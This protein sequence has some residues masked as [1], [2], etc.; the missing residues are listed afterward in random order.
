MRIPDTKYFR[1][2]AVLFFLSCTLSLLAQGKTYHVKVDSEITASGGDGLSWDK[3]ITLESALSL[4]KAGDEIWVKGYEDITGHIYKAPKGGFVLPSGVAMY[5]GFAGNETIKNDLPTGRHKYQMKYQTALV[6]DINTNDKASQQLIIYPENSTR[7]DNATHVLTLQMGVTKD[8]TNDG[9]KPTIVSGFLIAAGNAKGE[10]TSANGRGGGIYVVNNSNDNNAGSRY[11]RI[12]QC[13]F[14]N[15]YGMRGG[16]IYVD[17]S[18]TNQQSAIS[19]CSIFNNV[20]G[21]RGTSENEGGGM[22]IDGTATV[23]NC[24][25]NN[26]TNGGI[27]LSNT[28]KIVNC[29]VIANTVSAADLT[30]DGASN[31]NGGGAVYNTVL[32]HSTALSKQD[33]RPAFYS[34]AFPEVEVTDSKT[35]TDA[36]GN[37]RISNEN[38]GIEPAPWFKQSAV[39]Q[40]YDFSFS[41][42]L[43][44]L[45]STAFTF[46]ETSA[47]LNKGKLEYYKNLV[48]DANLE[49]AS[50]DIMG[51]TRYQTSSIDIGAY[52]YARMKAGRIRYVKPQ[53]KGL[54]DGSSWDNA[55]DDIQWAINDLAGTPGEKGEVWVAAGTYV[56]KDRIIANDASSPVSLLMKNGI[57]VYGAFKGTEKRRS[58][59]IEESKGLKPW[60][61]KQK[62]IIRGA[63]FK[64][65]DGANWNDNDEAW[66]IQNSE[67]Y[68]VV[69]FAPLPEGEAF[70]DEVYLEGFTIEGGTYKGTGATQYAPGYGAG[71]YI[72]D[73]SARMRYCTVRF[74]NS[75][76][77]E[78]GNIKPRGGGIYCKNG[79]TE[80]NLVYDCSAYQGGG[81]YID[82]AGFI[83][84]SMVTNCSAYQ[85]AGVYLNGDASNPEKAYYQILATSVISNN[86]STRNGA[87]YLYGQGLVINNTIVNNYTNNTSDPA[88]ELSS[89]TG[90]VYIKEKGLLANNVIWN[91]SLLQH[92]S[93]T[94]NSASMAQIYAANPSEKTV[95]FYNNAISDVNAAKWT[96]T[97]Q[98]GTISINTY[99]SGKGFVMGNEAPYNTVEAFNEK[100][101][102]LTDMKT[103][104]YYWETLTG[105][106]L[107]NVGISYA[108]LPSS[109]LYQP[110]ID[111]SG[112]A[113][114]SVPSAGAYMADNHYLVFEKNDS[115]KRLR[116]YFDRSRELVDGTGESWEKSYTSSSVDEVL[117]YLADIKDG[118][119]IKV[120][121]K[122]NTT[123]EDFTIEKNSGWE[124]E[125]CGREGIFEPK[126]AYTFEE[127]DARACTFNI[128]PCVLPVTVYG[129]YPEYSENPN[130]KD[131][132]RDPI[133]YRTELNG[134]LN[135]SELNEGL[136]HLV[137]IEAGANITID[138][139]AFTHAYAAG[140]AYMP[141]GGGVLIGSMD[142]S[143]Q[144]TTVKL[145]NCIFENNTAADGGAIATMPDA[146]NVTLELEN[147]I[148]NNNTSK[149]PHNPSPSKLPSIIYLNKSQGSNNSLTLNHVS[150][151]NNE[152]VAPDYDLVK[153][154]S[155][156]VGNKLN[157]NGTWDG[158][159]CKNSMDINT[160]GKNGALNFSN[161]TNEVGAR[162]SGNV[163]YGGYSSF[164]PLTSSAEAGR[165]INS[166]Q[167]NNATTTAKDITGEDRNLGGVPDLGAYEALLP[168]AGKI[169][170]VRSYN[171]NYDSSSDANKDDK[172]G[173][174][175]FNLL[176]ESDTKYD[177]STWDKAIIGNAMCDNTKTRSGNDFYVKQ[178]DNTLLSTTIDNTDY[179]SQTNGKYRSEIDSYGD[180]WTNSGNKAADISDSWGTY[181]KITNNREE[182]YISGLQY[183]VERAAELNK[184]KKDSVVVWVGAGI[185]TDYKGFVIR[186]NVKV[187]GGFPYEGYPTESDRHPLL[188]QYV[189]ARKEYENLKKA[190]YE[191]ILQIRKESPVYFKN[192]DKEMWYQEKNPTD[193]SN[194]DFTKT[195]INS[196]KTERH[197]VLYQPD[198]CLPT[199]SP[200]GDGN[201]SRTDGNAVRYK[202]EYLKDNIY[203]KDYEYAKWDGFS[204]RHGY[205]I[206]Y[207]GAN[208]DGGAGV[209]VFR[210]VELEN[211]IIVNNFNHGSR[212][213]GGGLYMDGENSKISNSYLLRNL[214]YA[215]RSESYGG[216]AY[217]IQGTGY[218]LVVANNRC[219]NG[220][221]RGG[222]IFLESAKFYNN[223]IAYNMATNGTGIYHWQDAKTG[224]ASQLSLYNCIIYDNYNN[225]KQIT[226]QVNSAA[227]G[228]MNP[229]HNCYMNSSDSNSKFL[230]SDG[231]F[232]GTDLIFPFE[233][234]TYESGHDNDNNKF[235]FRNARLK[236]NF[237]LYETGGLTGNKCLNGG[238]TNVG[239]GIILPE[240]DMDYT[241]RIKDC[242]IDIG[243][244]EADNTA[245]I[246]PQEKTNS[247]NII[248]YIYYVTQNGWG[249]RSGDS[250][251][252]AACA[253]KLQDV[254]TAAGKKFETENRGITD[255][256]LKHQVFVKVAGYQ[257]DETGKRFTYHANTLADPS[258]PQSYTFLIPNGVCLMGGY[259][260][261]DQ[262]G[263]K[264]KAGTANW[265]NDKRDCI[266]T[267]QTVLS[268]KTE[269]KE[270][271]AVNQEV[272][273]YHT[274]CFGKWPTGDYDN[275]NTTALTDNT[276]IDG[277]RLIDGNASDKSGFKSMGGAAIVPRKAHVRN[278]EI[279]DC[280]ATLGGALMLLKGSIVSGSVIVRNKAQK[281]GAIYALRSND[282]NEDTKNYH[283][284]VISC[285]IAKN[286]ATIGGGIYQEENS[287]IG[288]N[289]VI[290]GNTAQTDNNISGDV[291][292]Q[293]YDYLQGLGAYT[294]KFY[295]YNYCFVEKMA[296]PA[297]RMNT[298]MT[299]DLDSYFNDNKIFKP[300][301]YSPLIG[302][303][304]EEKYVNAWKKY[305]ISSYDI[306]GK[307]RNMTKQQ[308]AGAYT[309]DLPEFDN[310]KLLR[311]LFVS[312]T[313]GEIVTEE[314]KAKYYGRSFLTPF[315]S[316]EAAL[317]Y[318]NEAREEGVA[319]ETTHF[320]ILMTG[321]T[322]KPSKMRQNKD[323]SQEQNTIDRRLQSFTI[324]MNVDIFGSFSKDDLYSSTPVNPKTGEETGDKF[325]SFGGKTLTP[326]G[327]IKDIL[328]NRNKDY[329]TDNN[330]NGLIEPW[331]F[332]NPTILSGDIKASEKERNV[333]HVVYSNA[334]STNTSTTSNN[335]VVLD[336]ITIMNGETTT[337]LKTEEGGT[338]EVAEIGRGGGIY[339]NRVNYTLNR[340]RLIKNSGLHGGAVY[341]NN[342]SLDIIGSTI[343]GNSNVSEKASQD[344]VTEPGKGGAIYLYLTKSVNG[345][346]HIVNSLLAN[347]DV[348]YGKY[349][350]TES[351]QGGAIYIRRANDANTMAEGYQDAYIVNSLIVNNK[352][353]QDGAIHVENE[354]T[355][356]T[357][358]PI[359]YNTAIWGNESTVTEGDKVLLK[360]EHMRNCAWD[361]LPASTAKDGNVKLNKENIA[362]DGPRFTAPTTT[363]GYE[364]YTQDAKWNPQ[365]IS[366]LTDAGDGKKD[367]DDKNESGKYQNW[368]TMHNA[369]L[370]KYGYPSEYI[371]PVS[372][373][374]KRYVGPK[375][376]NG[377][378]AEK[379]IDIG[380]YEFQY[381]FKFT[382]LEKVYIGTEEKGNGDG[383]SWDNQS[384]D[385]RGAIIAM[386]NP[387]GNVSA[388]TTTNNNRKVFVRGGTYY[389]PTYSSGDAFSLIVNNDEKAKYITSIELVGGCTGSNADG[390]EVQDFSKPSVLIENPAK[391]GE[392]KNLLN[393]VTNGKPVTISGFTFQNQSGVGV[394]T[395]ANNDQAGKGEKMRLHHCAF[396]KNNG[397]G[398]KVDNTLGDGIHM[399]NVLFADGIGD[400]LTIDGS[401]SA[402]ITNATFVN[403]T[404]TAVSV[405][406]N[407]YNSVAWKNG[408]Q[409]L[410][411]DN[412]NVVIASSI[413]N[414]DVLNGPNFVDPNNGDYR[415]RPSLKLLDQ[416]SNDRY[417]Q[418]ANIN[419]EKDLGNT[420]RLIGDNIDIGAYECDTKMIQIIYVKEGS[421]VAGTG[422]SW[423]NPT[424][425]LQGAINLAELYANKNAGKYGYVFV[426]RNLKTDNVSISMPGVKMFGSMREEKSSETEPEAIV[427]DLLT[428]RKGIIESSSQS[429]ING[430]TLNSG[431]TGTETRM[432]LVDG[433]KV[434]GNI[435]LKGNSMLSTSIL[436]ANA[437]VTGDA[438]VLLYNSLALGSVKDVKSVNVTASGEL[439][440]STG[441]AANRSSVTTYNKYVKDDYW[442]YQLDETDNAN[443]NQHDANVDGNPT[444]ACTVQVMHNHDLAGNQRIRDKVDNGCFETWYLTNDAEAKETDYPHG[445][446]VVYVMTEDKELKLDNG[447]YTETNP[448]SPGFLLLKHHA[449]LRGNNSYVNLTYFA[450]ER[451]LK[452][453][454]NFFSMPFKATKMEVSGFEKPET[455][456]VIAYYYNAATR[457]K[458][459]YKFGKTNSE[460]WIR[461]VDNQRNFTAGFRMDATEAKTVRFYGTSY[462]EKDGRTNRSLLDKITLVQN[463][464]KQPWSSSNGGGLK[465]THKE[466]MG[467]NLFGSPYLCAMNYS[468]MEYGRV[469]YQYDDNDKDKDK[470]N[471]KTINTYDSATGSTT[472]GYIPAM[473]AV[474]TQTAT[475]DNSESVIVKHSPARATTA[476]A[477]TRAL[478]IAITQNSRISRAGNSTPA[479]DQLQLNAVPAQEAKS[480]FDLGSDGV[481]W[482]TSQNAQIYATRNGGRYS[483]LSAISIEAEQSIGISL[484]ETGEYTISIPEECDASEYETVWL[485]DKETGKAINLKEGDYRFH[486]SQAGEQNH[487]FTISFNRMAT[488]MKSDISI[489]AIGFRTIVLKGLQ[490]NDLISVYAA[491]GVLAL[492]KKAKAEKEQV[493]TA[494][495]GNVIVE[496]TRGGKQVAVRKIALK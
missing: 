298:E 241:N 463:N 416:G 200:S 130:P 160:L 38:H 12:S 135:G 311:R 444:K 286:E 423:D 19:Y 254:L 382:D 275:Y 312:Q 115:K 181:N 314:E 46:E 494:I 92:K 66:N 48:V 297:N 307:E 401:Q 350:G 391:A 472:D 88:D 244:Y 434:S 443:I 222:G 271:S 323:L 374:Y 145:K 295:P 209:R 136:Y 107:R 365:A 1:T 116:I 56:V 83:T 392:T 60:G 318:I 333:Y 372:G 310:T 394:N 240:T 313:G 281:G 373:T 386:A 489:Q 61:W 304:V 377:N 215:N 71:V 336:G 223:T 191:T 285:T 381:V 414:G 396:R 274:V 339:T 47:L 216:G 388:G 152:G 412:K 452:A 225:S 30:T 127:T 142:Q 13:N 317:D 125:I 44:Q 448:F 440:S 362:S 63:E 251:E 418:N 11:F 442:K 4:A 183:A 349:T 184:I 67:S 300:R 33:S 354:V 345:N 462:T 62:S 400:G 40:G 109:Y 484:P 69:W 289:S 276:I 157:I 282:K 284:Y 247:A 228:K 376:E 451:D 29:S 205:I 190:K 455:S 432:C 237:R 221:C 58:E 359:L 81:I 164:R 447:L 426:D 178:S 330:K 7:T 207:P 375:D 143:S 24:N 21:K 308:T 18:C 479:D 239:N 150:I 10:N 93:G 493:R 486:A 410:N 335:E 211:L 356:G 272:N 315:N 346:L 358:T 194:Y 439:P 265:D 246:A 17:N 353:K 95:Q 424:N 14:A 151:I 248:D 492:Q 173:N 117:G 100:R 230:T 37:V 103:V 111:L 481:K 59:R 267:Y 250:P 27:R 224:V 31:S 393:I 465:F 361:E 34:C 214:S 337:K 255:N 41:S 355:S 198:V 139:Y 324:P 119:N 86:T 352:A 380:M 302:N 474:F 74:C 3:A 177:G 347:N 15:N 325:T 162:M 137:R 459:D 395:K 182:Q 54:G 464:N 387:S 294:E 8:N 188:S 242:A 385:L 467:W 36:N 131:E 320:E 299:S 78:S 148:I 26:N 470:G 55:T 90:G 97:Y 322:Y 341:V 490:P 22:W 456:G 257:A 256:T 186:D 406:D 141:Y 94:N 165:I 433:F 258:D 168:K 428:Q 438:S 420:A 454:T 43:K 28:S 72:N 403:N 293:S 367:A 45:Y 404:G 301:A 266:S 51:R 91:N 120:V 6:G 122:D 449:G 496:V 478:D 236:N 238:T 102:V 364:G 319:D 144:A 218:N 192:G 163:Y 52:E 121:T 466:N 140:T 134:N 23:Y 417:Q 110:K 390:T 185:Y 65:S 398:M 253:D 159:E 105:S 461:G 232:T 77:K 379:P 450:V 437:K 445:K 338:T 435:S 98:S 340:C 180:F 132:D 279:S 326:D 79:Q 169:I 146:V 208:R 261:G 397:I 263:G 369:R 213:R 233:D 80:G 199:W 409:N 321:G 204:V 348:T 316:L 252:N 249:N 153:A 446:S 278:C 179:S 155:Y 101:G 491:D 334:G 291:N 306:T 174:P 384:T 483:L 476:Y 413:E 262:E 264:P 161:P 283:A 226:D 458:Y 166:A 399:W 195:L 344:E 405:T 147:C 201:T 351:S 290:W 453:G 469:I 87:V 175:D 129:G 39:T 363:K 389:S 245:N 457:A 219:Y 288:G 269:V 429:T 172:D 280:Q 73:P 113:I 292:Y 220:S 85:G 260:E 407:V 471:Y 49:T 436:D 187:Y 421:A 231:N 441:S 50:T 360:R 75:G 273:G 259:Y 64:G 477:E 158:S 473:D 124:F 268:A 84:R 112:K 53:K 402:D 16:A 171:Q 422:E 488:D 82:E 76:M 35:N 123:P 189:P 235:R 371:R 270:G 343:S 243:A 20:A 234:Q 383:S 196:G 99:Y 332:Q 2:I 118:D 357:I 156:A 202:E 212:V 68:H 277:C 370:E 342:A 104:N 468:D 495:Q 114:S 5:G 133:K 128:Q 487:R 193:G 203:Y 106:R 408:S 170:Y 154:T 305:G 411:T 427:K 366:V 126:I 331:E 303:G 96:S 108:L 32:W 480:D 296:L 89:N 42:N 9:N 210:G 475:L 415:I 57:S 431:T 149:D 25:I 430:L 70:T 138:G 217:M 197:Y 229:S 309:S 227:S 329:M 485:K 167:E 460:A 287:L 482:M 425:D 378:I 368:W 206:N 328:A 327:D 419:S 176:N